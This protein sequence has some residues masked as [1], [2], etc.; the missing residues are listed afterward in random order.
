[1]SARTAETIKLRVE[2]LLAATISGSPI[3]AETARW[4][5]SIGDALAAKL[6]NVGLVEPRSTATLAEFLETYIV[7]RTDARP[8]TILNLRAAANRLLEFLGNHDLRTI[9]PANADAF[10]INLRSRYALA[11]CGRTIK[12]CRQ[13][14]AVAMRQGIVGKNPFADVK[15]P[16]CVNE[17]R[18]S[19]IPASDAARLI[20]VCPDAEW[21]LLV[22]L[23]RFGG[24][25]TPSE[26]LA[27]RWT[28]IDWSRNRCRVDSPK[29]GCRWVPIFPELLPYLQDAF[30]AAETGAQYIIAKHRGENLGTQLCRLIGRAGLKRWS[31]VWHNMRASRQTE[32]SQHFPP[33][34]VCAWI[35]NTMVIAA[36]HYLQVT[37]A[38]FKRASH[39]ASQQGAA[40]SG[41]I[42]ETTCTEPQDSAEMTLIA[43]GCDAVRS[44]PVP[45]R[46]LEPRSSG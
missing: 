27:L 29:T 16:A 31:R 34:V 22:A 33:H 38:D 11:T 8:R 37:D 10:A 40:P 1:V 15:A 7:S 14:F 45:P 18:K 32:L 17:S 19:F 3:D 36:K 41:S 35:G 12:R 26:S 44:D 2:L 21:R 9:T 43:A 4:L 28:D 5:A 20:D 25:R 30:D 39:Y 46:G 42:S 13:F 6:A 24:L 23:S